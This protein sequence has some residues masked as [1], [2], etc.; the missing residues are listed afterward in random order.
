MQTCI[1]RFLGV[2]FP[3][4]D[5]M[6]TRTCSFTAALTVQVSV[7]RKAPMGQTLWGQLWTLSGP[8]LLDTVKG[9]YE[10]MALITF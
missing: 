10:K 2:I 8:D 1:I 3:G 5:E 9:S 4:S 7:K 6:D